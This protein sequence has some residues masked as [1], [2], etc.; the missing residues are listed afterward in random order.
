MCAQKED[1]VWLF[2]SSSVDTIVLDYQWGNTTIDFSDIEPNVFYNNN[3]T[4]DFGGANA[5]ICDKDGIL[6]LYSNGMHIQD[7]SDQDIINGDT[8]AYSEYWVNWVEKE[9]LPDGSDWRLGFPIIQDILLLPIEDQLYY[10]IYKLATFDGENFPRIGLNYS[11]IK[12]NENDRYEVTDKNLLVREDVYDVGRVNTCRHANGRDWWLIQQ[13]LEGDSLFVFLVDSNGI[14]L[15]HTSESELRLPEGISLA[16]V[17]FSPDGTKYAMGVSRYLNEI[18]VQE[19]SLYDFDRCSG[20]LHIIGH[21]TIENKALFGIIAFS[22]NSQYLYASTYE[23]MYQYDLNEEDWVASAAVVAEYD[24]FFFEYNEF[25]GKQR[26]LLG[27]MALAPDGR[28]YSV[29]PGNQRFIHSIEYPD[30]KGEACE[31]I[32]HK[33]MLPTSNFR[34]IPN[35]P[36]YRL[37]PMDGSSCDTL[38]LDNH[39]VAQFRFAQDTMDHLRVRFT[40]ISY[41]RPETWTWD[42]GDG[43]TYEG[44]KPYYHT[45]EENGAYHV[46]LTVSNENGED[47]YCKTIYLGVTS[48]ED[49]TLTQEQVLIYPN[50]VEDKL[51]IELKEYLPKNASIVIHDGLGQRVYASRIYGG[52]NHYDVSQ[53]QSGMYYLSIYDGGLRYASKFIKV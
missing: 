36:H 8:I 19:I 40:D 27:P 10:A 9:H 3:V 1:N 7:Y 11:I 12:K 45:Y 38:G 21:D 32:Q 2:G 26:T 35:F 39:C 18:I 43:N 30:E 48:T 46:C 44:K 42:F 4:M 34:S 24:G 16:Q 47:K 17:A 41:Y 28:V 29:P 51:Y 50:P 6:Q 53:L 22:P 14:H 49:K 33:I 31:V 23:T 5:S 37:G 25:T 52:W 13:N 15:K 20:Q